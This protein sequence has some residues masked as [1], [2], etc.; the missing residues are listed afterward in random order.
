VPVDLDRVPAEGASAPREHSRVAAHHRLAA[1]TEPVHVDHRGEVVEPVVGRVL[2]RLPHRALGELGV[3]AKHPDAIRE[4]VE[5]LARDGHADADG[6]SLAE[7]ARG[8][9]HP[10]QHR[11]RV[12]LESGAELPVAREVV[13]GDHA[14]RP[15]NPVEQRRRMALGED[16]TVVRRRFRIRPVVP[17]MAVHQHRHEVGRGHPGGWVAGAGDRARADRVDAELLT[18]FAPTLSGGHGCNVT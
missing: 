4:A 2:E 7:R 8:D 3:A 18:Q 10:R 5:V 1:L 17:E 6:Q 12:A 13:L 11:R 15:E 16:E 9:V 14:R